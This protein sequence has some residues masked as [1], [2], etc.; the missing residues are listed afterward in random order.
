CCCIS[1]LIRA[2]RSCGS[3][4]SISVER[5]AE[6]SVCSQR[7]KLRAVSCS[8]LAFASLVISVCRSRSRC[9]S[10]EFSPSN[11]SFLRRSSSFWSAFIFSSRAA[12]C[13]YE[14]SARADRVNTDASSAAL[15]TTHQIDALRAIVHLRRKQVLALQRLQKRERV[16]I[17]VFINV[18]DHRQVAYEPAIGPRQPTVQ[19]H[20][21]AGHR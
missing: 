5:S 2:I 18:L 6:S 9:C 15:A 19:N 17:A 14:S 7:L 4:M 3:L 10:S 16:H 20:V 11:R 12:F 8:S 21:A 1:S 13:A